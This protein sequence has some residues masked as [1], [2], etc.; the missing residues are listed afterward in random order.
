MQTRLVENLVL[1]LYLQIKAIE[2][3]EAIKWIWRV[4]K[5]GIEVTYF[6]EFLAL[7]MHVHCHENYNISRTHSLLVSTPSQLHPEKFPN[8]KGIDSDVS[9]T[10]SS[11]QMLQSE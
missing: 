11:K 9:L 4:L 3:L 1:N 5:N 8:V 7:S 2:Q 10:L 6:L